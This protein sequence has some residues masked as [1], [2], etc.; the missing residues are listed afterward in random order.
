MDLLTKSAIFEKLRCHMYSIMNAK[1]WSNTLSHFGEVGRTTQIDS[2]ISAEIPNQS[3]D[4]VLHKIS[5]TNMIHG[6]CG[7]L[8]RE[9][10]KD[11]K[12]TKRYPRQ[13][14]YINY[15]KKYCY[16]FNIY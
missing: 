11:G 7:E 2:V 10:K 9:C 15:F 1:A 16:N 13:Y 4:H 8:N 14:L 6:P 5:T 12:Y 3:I